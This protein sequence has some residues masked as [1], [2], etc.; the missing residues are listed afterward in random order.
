[1]SSGSEKDRIKT[2]RTALAKTV[3][4][5]YLTESRVV[6]RVIREQYGFVQLSAAI[7][8]I[9]SQIVSADCLNAHVHPDELGLD[10]FSEIPARCILLSQP[11]DSELNDL[12]ASPVSSEP[13]QPNS[14]STDTPTG[15]AISHTRRVT[16][17]L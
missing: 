2:L 11:A 9:E 8:H 14:P 10:D 3:P 16:A 1:M 12:S 5:A 7:P 15:C 4:G 6:R 13:R 17:T